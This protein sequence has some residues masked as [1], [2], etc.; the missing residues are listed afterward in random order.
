MFRLQL[1]FVVLHE[2]THVVHGH[3][4]RETPQEGFPREI[5][6]DEQGSLKRQAREADAD[7]YAVYYVLTNVIGG[8]E[9]RAHLLEVLGQLEK[10][11]EVQDQIL[12]MAFILSV[13]VFLFVRPPQAL[14]TPARTNSRTRHRPRA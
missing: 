9:E 7:G 8:G 6:I 12:L 1:F 5:L 2:Y 3:V 4:T 11:P 10:P 14:T 13:G